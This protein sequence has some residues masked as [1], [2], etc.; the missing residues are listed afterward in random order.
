V[1]VGAGIGNVL[2]ARLGARVGISAGLAVTAAALVGFS[3]IG[4]DTSFGPVGAALAVI[5][6]GIG[7]ALPT[8]LD[9][10]LATLPPTQTGAGSALTRALQQIA[11]TFGVAILGSVLNNAYQSQ[12]APQVAT[13][14]SQARE[15]ALSSIAGAHAI[16][17]HLP[18]VARAAVVH[19][20]NQAYTNGMA[21]VMLVSA[22]L[23]LATAIAIAVFLPSRITPMDTAEA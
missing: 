16:A 18:P 17:A 4:A 14:P 15:V 19:A 21:E 11:A 10:I 7:I 13:L 20:A 23:V 1:I 9:I 2:A 12:I 3:R 8:T 5:G 6:I 22:A